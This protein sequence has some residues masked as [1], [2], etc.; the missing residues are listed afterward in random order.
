MSFGLHSW[1]QTHRD[2]NCVKIILSRLFVAFLSST[3]RLPG[4]G[5]VALTHIKGAACPSSPS[6]SHPLILLPSLALPFSFRV[7]TPSTYM[8]L[9]SFYFSPP[10]CLLTL[11]INSLPHAPKKLSSM[12]YHPVG[13]PSGWRVASAWVHWGTLFPPTGPENTILF[14]LLL[15]WL[16]QPPKKSVSKVNYYFSTL[17]CLFPHPST[18]LPFSMAK[19]KMLPSTQQQQVKCIPK[20]SQGQRGLFQN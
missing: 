4:H 11:P 7:P 13:G 19:V 5:Q 8:V 10:L 18:P 14:H 16:Q 15:W 3:P 9:A 1:A 2:P 20:I 6:L 17:E 12:L